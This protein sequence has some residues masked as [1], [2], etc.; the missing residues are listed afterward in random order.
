MLM[1]NTIMFLNPHTMQICI[2]FSFFKIFATLKHDLVA[3]VFSFFSVILHQ[4]NKKG[5]IVLTF[6]TEKVHSSDQSFHCCSFA[7]LS[8][9]SS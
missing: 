2:V 4:D 8:L 5:M 3:V 6:T 9:K 7:T 1:K